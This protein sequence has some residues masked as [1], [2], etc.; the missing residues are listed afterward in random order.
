MISRRLVLIAM[1]ASIGA[2]CLFPSLSDLSGDASVTP[3]ASDDVVSAP[4]VFADTSI[5]DAS[6]A[7]DVSDAAPQGRFCDGV[8]AMFCEDFDEPDGNYQSRWSSV[9]LGGGCTLTLESTTSKST[10]NA[11]YAEIPANNTGGASVWENLPPNL[12]QYD[13]T[14]AV[15]LEPYDAGGG[16]VLFNQIEVDALDAAN[17]YTEYRFAQVPGGTHYHTHVYYPDGSNYVSDL[18]LSVT[19][20]PGQWYQV[21]VQL[22]VAPPP[23]K[24]TVIVDGTTALSTTIA[25]ATNGAGTSEFLA[26]IGHTYAPT[27]TWRIEVDNVVMQAK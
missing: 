9:S 27:G 17:A 15:R 22:S 18:P 10:P 1:G 25:Q 6:D 3:D 14:F 26:G 4:D 24:V 8:D 16:L 20:V 13:Y 19:F 23:A 21:E 11:L 7:G 5:N 12:T 2:G